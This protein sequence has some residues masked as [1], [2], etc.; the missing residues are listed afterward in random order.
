MS[1]R[2]QSVYTIPLKMDEVHIYSNVRYLLIGLLH[3]G[4]FS[5]SSLRQVIRLANQKNKHN[6]GR[7]V[8]R[9]FYRNSRHFRFRIIRS[10]SSHFFEK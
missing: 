1:A 6:F 2:A 10:K 4:R 8:L 7:Q 9:Q 3:K 5:Q